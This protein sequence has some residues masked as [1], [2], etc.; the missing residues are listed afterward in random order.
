MEKNV[1]K[2][3]R[4]HLPERGLGVGGFPLGAALGTGNGSC[5]QYFESLAASTALFEASCD[6]RVIFVVITGR[7]TNNIDKEKHL[8]FILL[9]LLCYLTIRFH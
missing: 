5:G 4:F 3:I 1:D 2:L 7:Q 6:E 8:Y 9:T